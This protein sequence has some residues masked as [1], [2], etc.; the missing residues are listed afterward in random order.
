MAERVS[1]IGSTTATGAPTW[2][3]DELQAFEKL[4]LEEGVVTGFAVSQY[5]GG[6]NMSVDV[7]AGDAI[8]EI[9]NTNLT[10][11]KTYKVYF[12]SDAVK[13]LTVTTADPTNPRKDRVILEVL[14]NANPNAAASNVAS[15]RIVAGT[16]AGS[17]SAPAE[18][19]NAITLAI[20]DV[21]A[22][23][24]TIS[25]GQ[26]TDSRTYVTLKSSVLADVARLTSLLATLAATTTGNGAS[27]IGVEDAA[28]NFA[29]STVEAALAEIPGMITEGSGLY[30][31]GN[32]G[33]PSWT[34][35]ASL[36]PSTEKRYV[37]ATLPVSQ[38]LSVSSVNTPL[39]LHST[40]NVT[41]NGTVDMN[42][43]GGAGGNGASSAGNGSAGTS[44]N[45][46]I[47]G[48]TSGNGSGGV[49][50]GGS[51]GGGG[52]GASLFASATAGSADGAGSG[53]AAGT[54][55]S[56]SQAAFLASFLRSVVCG[57]GGGG[58]AKGNTANGNGGAG[59]AGG[60]ALVW[61]IGG[62]LT[63]GSGAII[64]ANG[65]NGSAGLSS[66][67]ASGGGGG[68]GGGTILIIVAG[69]ITDGGATVSASAGTGGASG[70]GGAA[71]GA[72]AA[73]RVLI[74]S[75]TTGTMIT[76]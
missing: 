23:D 34:S 68:G 70:S 16:P 69:T 48:F 17:P 15:M 21:P 20:I 29:G 10:P 74:Y 35:G 51:A 8:I 22:G 52:G 53:G 33:T 75:L 7:A 28:G 43:K 30:G 24:T 65:A 5:S 1:I 18:P 14:V 57:A 38:T 62:N 37:N 3:D 39:V 56:A 55:L 40:G 32:D 60:G 50:S 13:T 59:G 76:A 11:S 45:S 47:S 25:T 58:G 19:S 66:S 44:G 54:L 61:F 41:I 2:R 4:F 73:G 26:I 6:A 27:R 42:G 63:L 64:R 67:G 12:N 71:G 46:K 49:G 72:G 31:D 36:D 9:T